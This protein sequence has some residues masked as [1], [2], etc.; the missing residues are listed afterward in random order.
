[1]TQPQRTIEQLLY[2]GILP[3][4]N[5]EA[6]ATHL[7]VYPSKRTWLTFF[8][9]ATLVIGAV[10]LV[11]SLVFFI[12]FNWQH[13]GKMGKFALVEAGLVISIALYIVLS[14]KRRFQ[15]IRQLLLLIAG[16]ITGSLL[17]LFGQVYQ[18]GADTWQLFFGWAVLIIPWVIIARF[19]ALWLL[20]LGL[21][22]A[23]LM[24]YLDLMD[25]SFINH[26]YQSITQVVMLALINFIAFNTW[27]ISTKKPTLQASTIHTNLTS[28]IPPKTKRQT[29]S[30]L[31]WSAY[32]VGLLSTF[33]IT[34]LAIVPVFED[35]NSL[36]TL[37][38]IISWLGWCGFM[39]WQ[40][41]QRRTDLLMLT[42]LSFSIITVVMFWVGKWLLDNFDAGGFLTLALLLIGMSSAVVM[43]LRKV[44]RLDSHHPTFMAKRGADDEQ[45]LN[46]LKNLGLINTDI[47]HSTIN[48]DTQDDSPWFIQVFFGFS[49]ILA[50]LFFIGFLTLLLQNTGL[51]E[52]TIANFLIGMLLNLGGFVLFKSQLTKRSIFLNS[53][54]FTLSVAGQAYVFYALVSGDIERPYGL[55]LF[56]LLQSSMI[57]IVPNFIYRILSS[58]I[59]L[60]C[61]VYLLNYYHLPEVSLGLLA[62]IAI[63]SN[64]QCYRL[65]QLTSIKWRATFFDTIRAVAYAS[66]LMLLGVSVYFIAAEYGNSFVIS[67]G[68]STAFSYNYYLAQGLLTVASLYGAALIL[69]RYRVS[70]LSATGIIIGCTVAVFGI[71]SIYVSGLLATSLIIIIA[72]ANSQRLFLGLGI[73][74]LVSYIFWY[75]YQLDTSL[76]VKSASMLIIGIALLLIR[77]LL[78]KRYFADKIIDKER[79]P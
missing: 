61:V 63:V 25:L 15:L 35:G 13:M 65:L 44:S 16:V 59:A 27:L 36:A 68:Y 45:V 43:W 72:V 7:E 34:Y 60:G 38:A 4:K 41:Y 75:Y 78:I 37:I 42:Y 1:M 77:W 11:L 74:A 54:A 21:I 51:L 79:L 8:D 6:A 5:T 70:L 64:L 23:G 9:T 30:R 20:W 17:A 2:Q 14:F 73:V 47:E 22:N 57:F 24:L 62:L 39:L 66:A 76:L 31:H 32:L 18:T 12:A 28:I 29:K 3:L 48:N 46:K 69:W 33:F 49:G 67:D 26:I 55:W 50:S 19:P 52:S 56:L 58:L 10:A 53:L 71:M 40:F